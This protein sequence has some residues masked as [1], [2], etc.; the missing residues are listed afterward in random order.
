MSDWF[1]IGPQA[2][3]PGPSPQSRYA[4]QTLRRSD[5]T[6]SILARTAETGES[7]GARA[8]SLESFRSEPGLGFRPRRSSA[9]AMSG[10]EVRE[11]TNLSDP[12][13]VR[14]LSLPPLLELPHPCFCPFGFSHRIPE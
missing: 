10:R 12:K 3:V 14:L 6:F 13:G 11:Y 2:Q 5:H 9:P 8:T 4:S 1:Q 7:G